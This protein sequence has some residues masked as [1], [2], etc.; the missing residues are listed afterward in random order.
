MTGNLWDNGSTPGGITKLGSR[1]LVVQGAGTY[2]GDVDI[3]A[4][5]LLAQNNTALGGETAVGTASGPIQGLIHDYELNGS[6]AD[7]LGGPSLAPNG[8]TLTASNYTFGAGQGLN[9]TGALTTPDN[10]SIEMVFSIDSLM[11][12]NGSSWVN[13][14][15]FK[16]HQ[17]DTGLYSFDGALQFYNFATGAS[18]A[19]TAGVPATLLLTRNSATKEVVGYVNGVEQFSFTDS[20]DAAVFSTPG[21][22]INFL[23]DDN[24]IPNENAGGEIDR[25]RIFD[26]PLTPAQLNPTGNVT[27]VEAGAALEIGNS[28][29]S[30]TQG[31]MGGL[32]VWG[33]HLV[34][35]GQGNA[36]F[37]D[38]AL[39][40][41]SN[42]S[43]TTNLIND[44]V[45]PTDNSWRGAISL[46][47]DTTIQVQPD[48][49]MVLSGAIDDQLNPLASG[50]SITVSG[51]GVLELAGAN[52]Y[53]GST[54]VNEGVL[55]IDNSQA[56]GGSGN[57]E[58]QT[59]TL[60]GATAGVTTFTLTFNGKTTAPILYTGDPAIDVPA[61]QA[62][63][64]A[65]ASIAGSASVGGNA[66]VVSTVP[67]VFDVTL[68]GSLTG[69]NQTIMTAAVT[70]GP[71]A[72]AVT[73][74]VAGSGGTE[75]ANGASLQLVGSITVAGEP[76]L[77]HGLGSAGTPVV[78]TQWF[79]VGPE[80]IA[81]GQTPAAANT[82]GRVTGSVADPRDP[83][84]IYVA[85]A[86]G[87][88]WKTIDGGKTW[89][90]IFDAIPEVQAITV[91]T[92]GD[93]T[94]TFDGVTTGALNGSSAT[95]AADITSALNGLSSIRDN[96]GYVTVTQSL[97]VYR[98][99]FGG[100]LIG[101]DVD[102]I[103]ATPVAGTVAVSVLEQGRNPNFAMFIGAIAMD[104]NNSNTI[105]LGTGETN[106]SADSYY[107]TGIYVSHD[108][109]ATW[110][111]LYGSETQAISVLGATG[112]FTLSFDGEDTA[113]FTYDR[114]A[115][116][117]TAADVQTALNGLG[118]IGGVGG[119]VTVTRTGIN[120]VQQVTVIGGLDTNND[121]YTFDF[122]G[123]GPTAALAFN[124]TPAQIKAAIENLPNVGGVGGVMTVTNP[125]GIAEVQQLTVDFGANPI[126]SS[127]FTLTFGGQVTSVLA[128]NSTAAQIQAALNALSSIGGAGGSV[129][130]TAAGGTG[131][132]STFN[133]T[134]GGTLGIYQQAL[135]T[136]T[137][138]GNAFISGTITEL[139]A[140]GATYT[141]IFGG[142]LGFYQQ[143]LL[144]VAGAGA[145]SGNVTE[146][147]IGGVQFNVTFGG[148]LASTQVDQ[149]QID[150]SGGIT[151]G[152]TVGNGGNPHDGRGVSKIVIDPN[153]GVLYA[154]TGDGGTGRNEVQQIRPNLPT[155]STFTLTFVGPNAQGIVVPATTIPITYNN[156][157]A[158]ARAQTA[159]DIQNALDA[160]PN[161]GG[162]GGF[163]TVTPP[164]GGGGGG[165]GGGRGRQQQPLHHHLRRHAR[166]D[167]RP[168][169][170]RE[171]SSSA[172]QPVHE[173]LHDCEWRARPGRQRHD[174]RGRDLAFPER[175]LVQHDRRGLGQPGQCCDH[176]GRCAGSGWEPDRLAARFGQPP[177][178]ARAG[179]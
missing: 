35:N 39:T 161:I 52:S 154:A 87:G 48:S 96:G 8:G 139:N 86:G 21:N 160:L 95:L 41:I 132:S 7:T 45:F 93:F 56:L 134:F 88:A 133:I 116:T 29:V 74:K 11:G 155:L 164:T 138:P 170:D 10:Y 111:V 149:I 25:I 73:E 71:G 23:I 105:Y 113:P 42:N 117:P 94:L 145:T 46:G 127:T 13:L 142:T 67:G 9:L 146:Q 136:F 24:I 82:T 77:V 20:T 120:E 34:L 178:H 26:R 57:A 166:P 112:D 158:A 47:S 16:N 162:V 84:I 172:R 168:A 130:V 22:V 1:R 6:Y 60:T 122:D 40:V 33:E 114:T 15:E 91:N 107:G 123:S 98:V 19:F 150:A 85:T 173:H 4:G 144:S 129:T 137:D 126:P 78:P 54:I 18:G 59:V 104:P 63:L 106:N 43:P 169:A 128:Y 31:L 176:T 64:N 69:F 135:I 159:L 36:F 70:V 100:T 17:A 76:L 14:I 68:G 2:T 75:I 99:T 174:G 38:A 53:R 28:N 37:G 151:G 115:N 147:S 32:G 89:R 119:T 65:L 80:S 140:G 101:I 66:T 167:Q 81:N 72:L 97:N 110:S 124:A 58:I 27:I 148:S 125:T 131:T 55:T 179:R 62:A 156:S 157:N 79:Q 50:S 152:V 12:A 30:Q 92:T 175:R 165:G 51:G 5:A 143:P 121:T 109:G 83:N 153:T 171:S 3:R 102:R 49:R 141:V 103:S 61:I 90:P 163:V 177:G 44:P 108:A 118:T